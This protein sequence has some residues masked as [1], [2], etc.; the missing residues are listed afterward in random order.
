LEWEHSLVILPGGYYQWFVIPTF[1]EGEG[2]GEGD[3]NDGTGW[4]TGTEIQ[5]ERYDK[6]DVHDSNG[7]LAT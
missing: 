2:E 6:V 3:V 5:T 4:I 1:N 7:W